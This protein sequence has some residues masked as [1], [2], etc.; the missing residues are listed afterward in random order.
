MPQELK[1]ARSTRAGGGACSVD[2]RESAERRKAEKQKADWEALTRWKG[3]RERRLQEFRDRCFEVQKHVATL[4]T[5]A[6]LVILAPYRERPF[7]E[8]VLGL[9]L[10]LLALSAVMAVHG[11]SFQA[12]AVRVQE[13]SYLG[14]DKHIS[15]ATEYS[16]G[17]LILAV[18]MLALFL[19]N[20]SLWLALGVF[21]V[22]LVG[23]LLITVIRY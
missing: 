5:A 18:V 17:L 12:E 1:R 4:S 19:F 20:I 16:S 21:V 9:A 2:E 14:Y 7:E 15:R 3:E 6:S 13:A 11:M 8:G 22:W 23:F 10:G